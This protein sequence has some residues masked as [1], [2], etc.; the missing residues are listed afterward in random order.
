MLGRGS[1]LTTSKGKTSP[2]QAHTWHTW[3]WLNT[4]E[5]EFKKGLSILTG[6]IANTIEYFS[7]LQEKF[8]VNSDHEEILELIK[9]LSSTQDE[10]QE[11]FNKM[12]SIVNKQKHPEKQAK[13]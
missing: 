8:F 10:M 12:K 4:P 1:C 2:E 3:D 9:D 11:E 6:I 5:P 13:F 7:I